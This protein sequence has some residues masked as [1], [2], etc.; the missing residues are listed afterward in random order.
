MTES[1]DFSISSPLKQ[2]NSYQAFVQEPKE[3][4]NYINR[5]ISYRTLETF[6]SDPKQNVINRNEVQIMENK[7]TK[8]KEFYKKYLKYS[9]FLLKDSFKESTKRR[10]LSQPDEIENKGKK[11]SKFRNFFARNNMLLNKTGNIK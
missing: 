10:M 5:P 3:D 6:S 1:L 2:N 4:T 11:F 8:L 9:D 7:K